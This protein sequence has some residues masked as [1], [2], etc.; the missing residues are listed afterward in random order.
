MSDE[1]KLNY[2]ANLLQILDFT[3]DVTQVSNDTILAHLV[4]QDKTLDK[5]TNDYLKQIL[6]NQNKILELLKTKGY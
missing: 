4:E 2:I 3:L 6:D 1:F 5:Q